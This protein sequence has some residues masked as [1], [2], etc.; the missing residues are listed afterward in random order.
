MPVKEYDI[1]V[2]D[3]GSGCLVRTNTAHQKGL[4]RSY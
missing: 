2:I 4:N 1:R 3:A